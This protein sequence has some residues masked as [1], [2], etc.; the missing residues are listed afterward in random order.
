[1]IKY[2]NLRHDIIR[3][4]EENIDTTLFDIIIAVFFGSTKAK[5]IKAKMIRWDIMELKS[6]STA[7]ESTKT[8]RQ[9]TK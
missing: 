2:L 4:L 6:F 5:Q 3:L 7:K 1:M 9:P 8:K